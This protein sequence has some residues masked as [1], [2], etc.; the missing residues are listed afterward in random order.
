MHGNGRIGPRTGKGAHG[1]DSR[2]L[3]RSLSALPINLTLQESPPWSMISM[4]NRSFACRP[5]ID[6]ARVVNA[7]FKAARSLALARS[8]IDWLT[9]S[10]WAVNAQLAKKAAQSLAINVGTGS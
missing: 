1:G 3:S 5:L 10:V 2:Q 4:A 7:A 9:S 8:M 6:V